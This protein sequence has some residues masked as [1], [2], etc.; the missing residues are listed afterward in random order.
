MKL[1]RRNMNF[2]N[3]TREFYIDS[4]TYKKYLILQMFTL[5]PTVQS[6]TVV[7]K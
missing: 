5:Q 6:F 2:F 7:A 1:Q 4:A 3:G